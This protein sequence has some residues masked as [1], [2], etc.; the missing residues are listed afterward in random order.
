MRQLTKTSKAY[1]LNAIPD[2]AHR[3]PL[4]LF[5]MKQF[6][7]LAQFKKHLAVGQKIDCIYHMK[8]VGREGDKII[9]TDEVQPTREVSIVQSNSFAV[10][11]ENTD[12]KIVNSWC[13]YPKAAD[14]KIIDNTKL[15][16]YETDRK[17]IT[18]P[19]LTLSFPE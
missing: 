6:S 15:V 4:N 16:I 9:Y 7:N 19:V 13:T 12:G 3:Q 11:T 18:L 17:G 1:T 14:A 8:F 10:K 2:L 5:I